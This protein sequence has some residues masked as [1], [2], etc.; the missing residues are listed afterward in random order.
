MNVKRFTGRNSR[1]AMQKVRQAFG[2]DAVV[3]S[4]KPAADGGIEI[5]AMGADGVAAVERMPVD[6]HETAEVAE[7]A[8]PAAKGA[9]SAPARGTMA[10][11]ANTVQD[12]V[13]QLAM[14]TLSFQDYVRERMLKRRQA[15]LTSSSGAPSVRTEPELAPSPQAARGGRTPLR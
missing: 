15:A 7:T 2:D 4:T 10:N 13:R 11:L 8:A 6:R 5:M 12:D 9:K 14:S 1:E 3:L